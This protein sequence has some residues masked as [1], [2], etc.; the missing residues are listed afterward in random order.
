MAG[1]GGFYDHNLSHDT[2]STRIAL[3][4]ESLTVNPAWSSAVAANEQD[5]YAMAVIASPERVRQS[6]AIDGSTHLVLA[7][8][9]FGLANA[10]A[11]ASSPAEI[12]L[13]GYQSHG[14]QFLAE[15]E[16][17][18][19]AAIWSGEKRTLTLLSDKFGSKPLYYAQTSSGS[20]SFAT[21]IQTVVA[22]RQERSELDLQ[23]FAQFFTFGHLW[24]TNT[25][26]T[27]IHCLGPASEVVFDFESGCLDKTRYWRAEATQQQSKRKSLVAISRSLERAVHEQSVNTEGLAIALSGGLDA[28]TI[29]ALVDTKQIPAECV[30]LGM[31]GSLDQR[32]AKR[33]ADLAGCNYKQLVLGE[34]F[35]DEFESHLDRMIDLTDGH[36]LSQCIVMPTLPLYRKL[37]VK[38]LLRGHVGELLHMHK[39]YNFS[40]D[41][42]FSQ[43]KDDTSFQ[44][45]LWPRLQSHLS[46][47]VD[48]PLLSGVSRQ[49][50]SEISRE[51]LRTAIEGT[52]FWDLPIDRLSQLF[53]DQRTRRETAMSLTKF[54]S[55]VDV[56]VPFLDSRFINAVFS[57]PQACR[58]GETSQEFI[59]RKHHPEFLK[60][61][62]SN[63][64]APV[65]ASALLKRACYY[66]MRV[67]AKLG[68]PGYQP[69]ERLGLWLRRELRTLVERVLL[70]RRC[71]DRGLLNPD[72]VRA[73]VKRHNVGSRNH[74]Y[75]ILAM[76]IV[77]L[78]LQRAE[79]LP[80][81][82]KQSLPA[83]SQT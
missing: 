63:T 18:F 40:I 7:G 83:F 64:G 79:H 20:F 37:G 35:L 22:A 75:L 50:F 66:R 15:L 69:Y 47:G 43:V 3:I 49:D 12:L 51:S 55:V 44:S 34:G 65:G 41:E 14:S 27:G 32:S 78:G 23:G 58:T 38:T 24:N 73:V 77:E 67:L 59:L 81:S 54:E 71:L 28:R 29:L 74:T 39:A 26:Y 17:R 2:V 21:S 62:N 60:P 70:D 16:G 31:E 52:G 72:C 19:V 25:F 9:I 45:W 36:Y 42:A 68:V 4:V 82:G 57:A 48:E 1:I 13:Q 61:A 76:I 80:G 6:I 56:R 8:E 11:K 53:L 33:L 10:G 46:D 30:S 5:P